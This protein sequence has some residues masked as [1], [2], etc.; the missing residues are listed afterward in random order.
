M[1]HPSPESLSPIVVVI[2][3]EGPTDRRRRTNQSVQERCEER[4]AKT[5][6]FADLTKGWTLAQKD[7]QLGY[8][9]AI[10]RFAN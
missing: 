6:R 3:G 9:S 5:G 2:D 8:V 10:E 1:F 7:H 4:E